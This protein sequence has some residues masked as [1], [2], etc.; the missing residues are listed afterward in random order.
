MNNKEKLANF[1]NNLSTDGRRVED[2]LQCEVIDF[3]YEN[4]TATFEYQITEFM[5]NSFGCLHGGMTATISDRSMGLVCSYF[6]DG[7]FTPTINLSMNYLLPF[8]KGDL[9]VIEVKIE[10][11]GNHVCSTSAK[12]YRKSDGQCGATAT[13]NFSVA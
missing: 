8:M 3:D 7:K 9:L 5:L 11:L 12:L 13:G 6:L 10:R 1:L 2:G 4:K